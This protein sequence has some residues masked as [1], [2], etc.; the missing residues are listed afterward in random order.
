ME[1]KDADDSESPYS[2]YEDVSAENFESSTKT[3]SR[4]FIKIT[5]EEHDNFNSSE[6]EETADSSSDQG[7]FSPK[8]R[9]RRTVKA[10]SKYSDHDS[11]SSSDRGKFSPKKRIR[12]TFNV[13]QRS[14]SKSSDHD[15]SNLSDQGEIRPRKRI[16]RKGKLHVVHPNSSNHGST[17]T[18]EHDRE[19]MAVGKRMQRI[20]NERSEDAR[21]DTGRPE[22]SLMTTRQGSHQDSDCENNDDGDDLLAVHP[23]ALNVVE[24]PISET[25]KSILSSVIIFSLGEPQH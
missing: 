1:R 7:K 5:A 20:S 4:K 8:K 25:G 2:D 19:E 6:Q 14:E 24:P 15:S 10:K 23:P 11:S 12:R 22:T 21:T 16:R 18:E 13:D 3:R 17:S 9:I